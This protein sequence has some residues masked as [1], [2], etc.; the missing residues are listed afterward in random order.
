LLVR[1]WNV[2]HGNASPPERRA[3]LREAV[4]LIS[5]DGPDVVRL[6][7]LPVWSLPCLDHWSAMTAVGDVAARPSIGPLPSTAE[8]GRL[9]TEPNHGLFRSLFTGQANGILLGPRLRLVEHQRVILNPRP[10]RRAQAR[11]LRL[12][13]VERLAW[14]KERRVCQVVRVRGGGGAT[15]VL[16]NLHATSF[17]RDKRLAAAEVRRAATFVDGFADPAEPVLLCGDF[18]LGVGDSPLLGELTGAEWGF[19]GAGRGIDHILVR[20]IGASPLRRWPDARRRV[21]GRLL[22]DHA[23]RE[24]D[25]G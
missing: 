22:S 5:A 23:P 19:D 25:V 4:R 10:Y 3:F 8:I 13:V 14:G 18:N 24:R 9:L 11:R 17:P 6:Q 16:A 1:T 12:G 20:G 2:F 15:L 7:E 21:D